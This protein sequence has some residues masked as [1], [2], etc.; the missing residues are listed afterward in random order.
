[1]QLI[2][3]PQGMIRAIYDET[4]DLSTFGSMRIHRA[5]FVE[6]DEQGRWF[7]DLA[8]V[9]GPKLGPFRLRSRALVAEQV[10]LELNWP[11]VKD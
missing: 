9:N 3:S 4:L 7:V 5:S 1:M 8:P 2:I 10:W 6:P 11:V